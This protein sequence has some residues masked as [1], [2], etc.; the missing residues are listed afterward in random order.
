M[1]TTAERWDSIRFF[2]LAP[3]TSALRVFTET[4]I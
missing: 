3:D 4:D 2:F 1:A